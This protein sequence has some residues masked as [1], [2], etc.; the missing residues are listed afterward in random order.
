[1]MNPSNHDILR[2]YSWLLA[3]LYF[4]ISIAHCGNNEYVDAFKSINK[5]KQAFARFEQ[6]NS[7]LSEVD[8][9]PAMG[10]KDP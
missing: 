4:K 9:Y 5:S 8:G 3:K 10:F 2:K 6:N 7:K 1:M